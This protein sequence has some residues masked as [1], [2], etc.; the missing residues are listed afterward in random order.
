MV[1]SECANEA[2]EIFTKGLTKVLDKLSPLRTI[3]VRNNYA[4]WLSDNTKELT[5]RRR[6]AQARAAITGDPEELRLVRSLRNQAVSG[7]RRDRQV[8]E[9]EKL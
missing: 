4:P 5:S 6:E 7:G 8:W 2:A 3:Q 9:R 1:N